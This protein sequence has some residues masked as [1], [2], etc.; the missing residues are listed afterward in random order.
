[1]AT[2][3]AVARTW[4]NG[5]CTR[6]RFQQAGPCYFCGDFTDSIEH[7]ARCRTPRE[8]GNAQLGLAILAADNLAWLWLDGVCRSPLRILQHALFVHAVYRAHNKLRH[9]ATTAAA[10][11]S[12]ARDYILG[13]IRGLALQ[14]ACIAYAITR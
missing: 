10:T 13:E 7:I 9:G 11:A 6:T 3:R 2:R 4:L 12:H 1:M 8:I 14:H 5:W